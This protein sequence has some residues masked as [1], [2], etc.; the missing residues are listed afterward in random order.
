MQI[1]SDSIRRARPLLGTFVEIR[2]A[3]AEAAK[4]QAAVNA[5]FQAVADVHR[6]MSF[7]EPDSDVSRIN[8]E[9]RVRPVRVH[10]WT[11]QVLEA[12]VD[13]HRRSKGIFDVTVAPTL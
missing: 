7:H 12:A 8:R 9:A 13:M 5:A 3:G 10:A 4:M 6:L 11:F 1:T 2:A